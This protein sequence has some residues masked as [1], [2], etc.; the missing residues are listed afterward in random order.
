MSKKWIILTSAALIVALAGV[1]LAVPAFAQEPSAT[2]TPVPSCPKFGWGR[3]FGFWGGG[4]WDA[5]DAAAK[6]LNLTPEQL[7]AQLHAG[8]TLS[9]IAEA[10]GVELQTVYDAVKAAQIEAM[11]S[12]I[13]QAVTDGKLTQEQADWLLKGIE[14]GFLP[15]GKHGFGFGRGFGWM[16]KGMM[17]KAPS[18]APSVT[19]SAFSL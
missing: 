9:E 4:G 1:V 10:Q 16:G 12:A 15:G 5:F 13:Q 7:F 19:P 17:R 14:L 3:G 8:K 2:P 11:K 18:A 6:A